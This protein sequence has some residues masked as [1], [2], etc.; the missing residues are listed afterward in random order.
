MVDVTTGKTLGHGHEGEVCVRGP[1]VMKGYYMNPKAT[2]ETVDSEGWLHTGELRGTLF[3][4]WWHYLFICDISAYIYIGILGTMASFYLASM[5]QLSTALQFIARR[6]I[7]LVNHHVCIHLVQVYASKLWIFWTIQQWWQSVTAL[8]EYWVKNK[9]KTR[10]S[11][12]VAMLR[13]TP[14]GSP[15]DWSFGKDLFYVW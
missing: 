6:F 9:K 2:A 10:Q 12:K 7:T 1:Q 4:C 13:S 3:I 5:I 11:G 15:T 8:V 14:C